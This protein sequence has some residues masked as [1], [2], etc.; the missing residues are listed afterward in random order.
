MKNGCGKYVYHEISVQ[1]RNHL[2]AIEL[3]NV[4]DSFLLGYVARADIL[5][6]A[7]ETL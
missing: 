4:L 3:H 6:V 2:N 7:Q 5:I 1:N